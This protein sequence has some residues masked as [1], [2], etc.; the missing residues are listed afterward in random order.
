MKWVL[1]AFSMTWIV[2]GSFAIL[3]TVQYRGMLKNI[4]KNSNLKTIAF[5]PFIGGILL[6]ICSSA[7]HY[8]W[9]IRI[10]GILAV[11]KGAFIF[12]N[13][14]EMANKLNDWYLNSVSD[15]SHRCIGILGILLGSAVFSWII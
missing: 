7:S 1:Y 10:I 13:P 8:P 2:F 5:F 15:Q 14:I 11:I 4:L 9:F 6:L 3:Y 12:V